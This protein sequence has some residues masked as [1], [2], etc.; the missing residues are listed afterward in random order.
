MS[1]TRALSFK[2]LALFLLPTML[3]P[4]CG[5]FCQE[6]GGTDEPAA[7]DDL[8]RSQYHMRLGTEDELQFYVHIWGQVNKP[9]LYLVS[10]GTDVV[11]LVSLAGGP[12]EGAQLNKVSL[13]RSAPGTKRA[14]AV[15][16]REFTRSGDSS[17]IPVLE[18]GDTVV[19]PSTFWQRFIRFGTVLSVAALVANVVVYATRD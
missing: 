15:D 14:I 1:L 19:V 10:D 12:T 7:Q 13:V 8:R 9:G 2:I 4:R 5:A 6:A 16:L 3:W 17:K 11:A 18:P